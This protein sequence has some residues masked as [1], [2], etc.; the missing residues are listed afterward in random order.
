MTTPRDIT[1]PP[2]LCG[3]DLLAVGDPPDGA[4]AACAPTSEERAWTVAYTA[5]R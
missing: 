5:S 4:A 2:F 1:S 3:S